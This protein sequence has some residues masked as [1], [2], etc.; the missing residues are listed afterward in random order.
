MVEIDKDLFISRKVVP[1]Y[2]TCGY[3]LDSNRFLIGV[4]QKSCFLYLEFC[5][6]ELKFAPFIM[7]NESGKY[8]DIMNNG[9][10]KMLRVNDFIYM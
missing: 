8:Y 7:L 10:F 1:G 5:Q 3:M 6:Q 9:I 2:L 4:S